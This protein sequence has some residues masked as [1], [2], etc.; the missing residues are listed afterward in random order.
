MDRDQIYE[1]IAKIANA[2]SARKINFSELSLLLN[3][4]QEGRSI[5]SRVKG[6]H[7]YFTN[8]GDVK[9]AD[10]IKDVYVDSTGRHAYE[11]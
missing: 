5:A 7:T 2:N 10:N 6:A 4:Q 9:T 1:E 3:I 8:K 11:W